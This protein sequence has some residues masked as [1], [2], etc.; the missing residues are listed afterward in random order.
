MRTMG[1]LEYLDIG[2]L[3]IWALTNKLRLL[4]KLGVVRQRVA[5]FRCR[6]KTR[7]GRLS[8]RN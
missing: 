4:N 2:H 1:R 6:F 7:Y 8:N 3:P 5:R